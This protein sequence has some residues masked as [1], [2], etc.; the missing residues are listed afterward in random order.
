MTASESIG[1][2]LKPR[3]NETRQ[4]Y[5]DDECDPVCTIGDGG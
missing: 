3:D 2:P 5:Y 1:G 4:G